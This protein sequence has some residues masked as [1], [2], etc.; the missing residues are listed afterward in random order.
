M[1]QGTPDPQA[2]R[3]RFFARLCTSIALIAP[4]F[5]G[6]AWLQGG[7]RGVL[8]VLTTIGLSTVSL[9]CAALARR[10][11]LTV[12]VHVFIGFL[13]TA[14][15]LG[16]LV[17]GRGGP[18]LMTTLMMST[19]ATIHVQRSQMLIDFVMIGLS[20]GLVMV[21]VPPMDG[22]AYYASVAL[23]LLCTMTISYFSSRIA[24][25]DLDEIDA[26]NRALRSLTVDLE[27]A[28]A[29]AEE[30]SAAKS[31]FLA[32]VSH[33]LRTPLNAVLGYAEMVRSTLG[34]EDFDAEEADEDLER[35]EK[36]GRLLLGHV[37]RILDLTRLEA[38]DEPS[39]EAVAIEP[40][41]TEVL[42]PYRQEATGRGL[43]VGLEVELAP[44]REVT[45]D[46]VRL[47]RL[48]A[49]LFE[50]AVRFTETGGVRVVA[51][52]DDADGVVIEVID[53]GV[54][55]AEADRERIFELFTQV[56]QSTTRRVEGVGLGLHLV[57]R[58][59]ETLRA[60]LELESELGHGTRVSLSLPADPSAS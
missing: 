30:A 44:G 52:A 54:G 60:T 32:S 3:A 8:G 39:W 41:L 36:A 56:D 59:A 42:D 34:T 55:I 12:S 16:S 47:E 17:S 5:L 27:T 22:P 51:R 1:D 57:K 40:L 49:N 18:I 38:D 10:G 46:R 35:V 31:M 20:A 23:L 58:L 24:A 50:N 14:L 29:R 53:T 6:V 15:P 19:M 33:E 28:T 2:R 13:C 4:L 25:A 43:E 7:K 48:L 26:S 45:T 9:G 37:S 11:Q 21:S